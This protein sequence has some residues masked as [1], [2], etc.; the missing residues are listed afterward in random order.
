[1]PEAYET[2][3]SVL[4]AQHADSR[5]HLLD[6]QL[7]PQP[8]RLI[9]SGRVLDDATRAALRG[10]LAAFNLDDSAVHTLHRPENAVLHVATNLTDLLG[11]PSWLSERLSQI[12]AGQSLEILE[13]HDRWVYARQADGYLG[14][15][16]LP[17]LTGAALLPPTHIVTAP[18]GLLRAAH[19]TGA[20]IVGRGLGG[21]RVHLLETSQDWARVAV[22]DTEDPAE[23]N[24][25]Q[26]VPGWLP[27]S[28]LRA[29]DML[30]VKPADIRAQMLRDAAAFVGVPYLWGG[31]SASGID[32][33]GFAQMLHSFAGIT[34][35]RDA[36]LQFEAG[37]P[38]EPPYWPGDLLF[39]GEK[40]E[41]RK[42]THVSIS[43]GGWDIIHSSRRR[44]GVAYDNVQQ[45]DG[46]RE[47]FAG[48]RSFMPRE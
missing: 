28:D 40:G 48:A 26:L 9:A 42:I 38:V 35:P 16:Y 34:L 27:L 8:G 29:L 36:D 32:C 5:F 2:A 46:L 43:V 45:V 21:V 1:M 25:A 15:A 10:A 11:G 13:T 41:Q 7:D 37:H 12:A 3:F 17:Y 33:S 6:V 18:V 20:R 31:S 22:F 4:R 23:A 47:T 44:N 24:P 19:S 14:W 39:Y 30:P